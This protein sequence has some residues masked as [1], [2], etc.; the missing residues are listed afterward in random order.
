MSILKHMTCVNGE[1]MHGAFSTTMLDAIRRHPC[2]ISSAYLHVGFHL[3]SPKPR[4][5]RL[6][7]ESVPTSALDLMH[8]PEDP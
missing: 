7:S 1:Q 4:Q 2:T 8:H 3:A 5:F 6:T